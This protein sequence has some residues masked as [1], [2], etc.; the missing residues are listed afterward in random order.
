MSLLLGEPALM[1]TRLTTG[2]MQTDAKSTLGL[3]EGD[4]VTMNNE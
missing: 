1:V 2:G 4:D 3:C